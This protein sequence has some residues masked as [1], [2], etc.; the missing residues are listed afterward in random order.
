MIDKFQN[1]WRKCTEQKLDV[2]ESMMNLKKVASMLGEFTDRGPKL[3]CDKTLYGREFDKT[4]RWKR[5]I[6]ARTR[7]RTNRSMGKI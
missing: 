6:A 7:I 2:I 3:K 5:K 1:F 4:N